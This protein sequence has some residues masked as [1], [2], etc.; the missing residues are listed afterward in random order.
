MTK[1][2]KYLTRVLLFLAVVL[3]LLSNLHA[4]LTNAFVSNPGLNGVIAAVL[5]I[6]IIFSI[7]KIIALFPCVEWIK[8]F[9]ENPDQPNDAPD[10]LAPLVP[11]MT[12]DHNNKLSLSTKSM[13]SLMDST[14]SRMDESRE[15]TSYFIGLLVFLGL[16]GTFWGLLG[17]ISSIKGT[18]DSLSVTS[19]NVSSLFEELKNGLAAPLGG[20]GTAF[21][22]SLF[23]LTGS[24]ILGFIQLQT[25]QA[26]NR[27]LNELEDWLSSIVNLSRSSNIMLPNDGSVP[28]YMVALFEQNTGSMEKLQKIISRSE[29]SRSETTVLLYE[30]SQ[31]LGSFAEFQDRNQTYQNK[32]IKEITVNLKENFSEEKN[33][34]D[35]KNI[36][37]LQNI[38]VQLKFLISETVKG[39]NELNT[40]LSSE[41]KLL[42]KTLATAFNQNSAAFN[43]SDIVRSKNKMY[44]Y[45]LQD[46]Q[47]DHIK[48]NFV[49]SIDRTV[50]ERGATL[51]SPPLAV[52]KRGD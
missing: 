16:I 47:L 12:K 40:Q 27:F 10:I 6:G 5:I 36:Y 26:Q 28:S 21:S 43:Q 9:Q 38:E 34:F 30:I 8:E 23:G 2:K 18:I 22:S 51:P 49:K 37:H 4:I 41:F 15:I 45:S 35:K 7:R 1:P 39:Q 20:M 33:V 52:N 50:D 44:S 46:Q 24:V 31:K 29:E 25:T 48:K 14:A 11:L 19:G 32:M 13:N 42:S 3:L 17:T